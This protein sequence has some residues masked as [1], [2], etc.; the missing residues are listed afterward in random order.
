MIGLDVTEAPNNL[1]GHHNLMSVNEL[2]YF[3]T[4]VSKAVSLDTELGGTLGK[5]SVAKA[6]LS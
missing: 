5:A 2:T 3:G 6:K 1:L 4:T